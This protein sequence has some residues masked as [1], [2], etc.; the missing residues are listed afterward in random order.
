MSNSLFPAVVDF[1][2]PK[3][4]AR[5]EK[6]EVLM[7]E[8]CKK[9]PF[10]VVMKALP[11]PEASVYPLDGVVDLISAVPEKTSDGF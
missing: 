11:P 7:P 4:S 2:W 8:I 3:E 1:R 5:L 9:V 6:D 10:E